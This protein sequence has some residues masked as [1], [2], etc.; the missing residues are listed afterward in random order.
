M[1]IVRITKG[2]EMEEVLA[3]YRQGIFPMGYTGESLITWHQPRQRAVLPLEGLHISRSLARTLRRGDYQVSFDKAFAD[4]M[5][6]CA[7]RS[8]TWITKEIHR[9]YNALH[10]AGY[11][12]SIEIW[13]QDRLAAGL[14]GV[15]LGGA[16]FAE[17]KFH[18]VRDMSKVAL[19]HLVWR[20]RERGFRLMD[21]QYWTQHLAQ[22][23]VIEIPHKEYMRLLEDALKARCV[24]P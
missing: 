7:S 4:V 2:L 18:A 20:L 6:G 23:G 12:H 1:D 9:V 14:Y 10:R 16:F 13:V 11:A 8:S 17:S 15:H 22:F 5:R 24:F 19:V 3:G 21:V